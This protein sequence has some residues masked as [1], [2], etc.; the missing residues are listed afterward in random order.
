LEAISDGKITGNLTISNFLGLL[1]YQVNKRFYE[2]FL[3]MASDQHLDWALRGK[4]LYKVCAAFVVD[5]HFPIKKLISFSKK[6]FSLLL[7]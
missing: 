3:A 4:G 1:F 2:T 5:K 7:L 6:L